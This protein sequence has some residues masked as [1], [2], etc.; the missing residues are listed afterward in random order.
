MENK[1][2]RLFGNKKWVIYCIALLVG[3]AM[4]IISPLATTH[5]NKQGVG[6]V[7][8]GIIS[9]SFFLA[10][11][12]GSIFGDRKMRGRDLTQPIIIGLL[13]TALCA[14]LFPFVKIPF[15][16]FA[17]MSIMGIGISFNLVG[18]QTALHQ[19]TEN[20]NRAVVSGIYTLCY[21]FGFVISSVEGPMIYELNDKLPFIFSAISLGLGII[22]IYFILKGIMVISPHSEEKV[23][24]KIV[25]PLY[26]VFAYG[27]SETTLV[28]LY[29]LYLLN[30]N[31]DLSQIGYALGIFVLG[32]MI[33]AV[34]VTY[35]GD[36]IGREKCLIIS[37]V[38]SIFAILGIILFGNF[39]SKLV[40]SFI[41][42]FTVG[43]IYPLTL[44]L[45]VQN[46]NEKEMPSGTALFNV[47]YGLGST[48]GPFLSSLVMGYFGNHYIFSLCLFLFAL[49]LIGMIAK[50]NY[51][52]QLIYEGETQDGIIYCNGERDH[53]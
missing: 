37:L 5:M 39:L 23:F 42:G 22:L 31:I 27:F 7:W 19:L 13:F 28:S 35:L 29:P 17:L 52:S 40:F 9:S 50:R 18:V 12:M 8:I 33:G 34:P 14:I 48:A 47:S 51:A 32:S 49:L 16:W 26:G 53:Q 25:M 43:P 1:I 41:A 3:G 36:K 2:R 45:S 11:V 10:M 4:G 20:G 6:P 24:T 46:L 44:A 21:A 15:L 30:L 38:I